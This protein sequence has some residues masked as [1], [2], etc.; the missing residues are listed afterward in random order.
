[1][2]SESGL[3]PTAA[4]QLYAAAA[5]LAPGGM[6]V[7]PWG[8]FL[9]FGVPGA[10]GNHF[11]GRPQ[12]P[13]NSVAAAAAAS[14]LANN[15]FANLSVAMRNASAVQTSAAAAVATVAIQHR[16]MIGNRQGLPPAGPPSEGSNEDGGKFLFFLPQ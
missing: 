3:H 10:F 13:P 11:L 12:H 4:L 14:Q 7:P 15:A 2:R 5:Q 9:Q 1:M 8:P 6:R 16:I